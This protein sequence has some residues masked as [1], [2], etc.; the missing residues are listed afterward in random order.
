ITAYRSH[1]LIK[2][3]DRRAASYIQTTAVGSSW[4][5]VMRESQGPVAGE[6]VGDAA[7]AQSSTPGRAAR[8]A[9]RSVVQRAAA[10]GASEGAVAAAA[11]SGAEAGG[12]GQPE[13]AASAG[14]MIVEDQG[15]LQAG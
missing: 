7:T 4:E 15:Q 2:R 11:T 5:A 13:P 9:A 12:D 14:A 3:E 1:P 10:E 8:N 6:S